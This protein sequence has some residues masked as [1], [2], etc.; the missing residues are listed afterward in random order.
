MIL[1]DSRTAFS[2][3]GVLRQC[4]NMV[5]VRLPTQ[6]CLSMIRSF[7]L[8]NGSSWPTIDGQITVNLV[9]ANGRF[10]NSPRSADV[11]KLVNRA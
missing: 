1:R 5:T 6:T 9:V 8:L 7:D 2:K 11:T 4:P 3:T 10:R